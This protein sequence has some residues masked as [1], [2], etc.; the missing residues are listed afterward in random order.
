V[1]D[2]EDY[3]ILAGQWTPY[4]EFAMSDFQNDRRILP[5][6]MGKK[7]DAMIEDKGE[8]SLKPCTPST[9]PNSDFQSSGEG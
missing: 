4:L 7:L 3:Y 5:K 6:K 1:P 2:E 9:R 8:D